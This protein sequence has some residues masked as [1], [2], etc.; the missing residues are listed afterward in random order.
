MQEKGAGL[1]F[2]LVAVAL[3]A[4]L[5]FLQTGWSAETP[6]PRKPRQLSLEVKPWKGDF[7][8]MLERRVIRVLAPYSRTM[9]FVDKGHERGLTADA[10][11]QFER[12]I[13]RKYAKELGKRPLTVLIIP[14]TRDKLLP[15]LNEGLGDIAAANLT[16]TEARLKLADFVV[17]EPQP[18]GRE[19]IV[20]GP[21]S[22]AVSTLEDLS[23]KTIDV[24]QS[25]SYYESVLALNDRLREAGKPP[26][27][28][29]LLPDAI[30]DEDALEMLNAGL[31]QLIVVDE[32]RVRMW[33]HVLP[34]IKVRDDLVMRSGG[35]I[36]WAIRKDSPK[37][38]EAVTDALKSM[39]TKVAS[40]SRRLE[41]Y[42]KRIKQISNNTGSTEWKRFE[43]TVKLFD[44]Y[45]QQYGFDPLMLAA[46]GYQESRLNQEAKSHVGAV[47][48]M[49]LMPA[50]GAEM[51][52]GDIHVAESNVHAGTKYMDQLMSLY[53]A[54]AHFTEVNRTLFAFA[55][56][57]AGAGRISR[58]RKEAAKR[59][60]DPNVW[61]NNVEVV[62]AEK[63]G[64]ETTTYV[65][66]IY[67]YYIAYKLVLDAQAAQA[68]ARATINKKP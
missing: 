38:R 10:V 65:R 62:V 60:L 3:S 20:S 57:N 66:N 32:W 53:F 21:N 45:G 29:T 9:Y 42:E 19:L 1:G 34:K 58:L 22:P 55:A 15:G 52:V 40:I 25:S 23:G 4:S 13:N 28:I 39:A 18:P 63:V 36:G 2:A 50:T 46:Q 27:Q 17:P 48:I 31:L 24:R 26:V 41:I 5:S 33:A 30:E 7:D 64:M 35:Q 67:K 43:E 16:V 44:K 8:G 47:G 68:K 6:A 12:Y 59:G 37:L 61:F 11:R 51:K 56:Y 14:T 54:G 49:Q